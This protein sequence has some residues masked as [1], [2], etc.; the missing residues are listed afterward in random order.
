MTDKK[1]IT[2]YKATKDKA[3]LGSLLKTYSTDLFGLA[4]YYLHD[5]EMAKDT[6]MDVFE[7][8]LNT[9]DQKEITYFK[10]WILGICRNQ[11]LKKL[12]T[13]RKDKEIKEI[14]SNFVENASYSV[15]VDDQI[16]K[17]LDFIDNLPLEQARCIRLFYLHKYSYKEI[18]EME[19]M[20]Y[21]EVK[22]F[23]Q[24]GKRKLRVMFDRE[25][26]GNH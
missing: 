16:E 4:Y 6:V 26:T 1:I 18:Q 9:I 5:R 15:Q 13:H 17:M 10:G 23:I 11:S 21:N 25:E 19:S 7:I 2:R 3:I 22:S 12:R 8:V 24:N 14:L 20:T